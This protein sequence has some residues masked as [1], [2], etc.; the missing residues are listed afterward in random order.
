MPNLPI[1]GLPQSTNLDGTE[2]LVNVQGGVTKYQNVQ[3]ILD[4]NLPI[5]SSGIESNYIDFNTSSINESKPGRLKWNDEDGTLDLTLKKGTVVLQM[6]QEQVL[7]SYNNTGADL[8]ESEYKAVFIS[9]SNSRYPAINLA[10]NL[11]RVASENTIGIVTEDIASGSLGYIT[12]QGMVRNIDMSTYNPGD[13]LYL[14]GAD[15]VLINQPPLPPSLTVI[16]GYCIDNDATTGS[17][18][19]NVRSG[20]EYPQYAVAYN[21]SNHTASANTATP[22]DFDSPDVLNGISLVSGSQF[23][24]STPGLYNFTLMAQLNRTTNSGT[25]TMYFWLRKNEQDVANT[26]TKITMA[27]NANQVAKLLTKDFAIVLEAGDY[28]EFYWATTTA[29][30]ILEYSPT[31]SNPTRPATPAAKVAATRVS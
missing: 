23:I 29:D 15:G 12:T 17:M 22:I 2:L 11:S 13:T 16:M 27:G 5:T 7:N 30:L 3:D 28:I 4:A 20:F 19:V 24:T 14:G 10:N 21:L 25:D 1:S 6:G 9:G 26:N 8:L 18:Y 31:G